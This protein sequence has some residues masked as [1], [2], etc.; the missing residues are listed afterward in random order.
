MIKIFTTWRGWVIDFLKKPTVIIVILGLLFGTGFY[1]YNNYQ[2]KKSATATQNNSDTTTQISNITN[3]DAKDFATELA[4]ELTL[5]TN[6]AKEYNTNEVLAAVEIKIPGSLVPRSGNTTYIFD[7]LS[8]TKNHFTINISQGTPNF[9]RAI[10]PIDDYF[11]K[12]TPI[13]QKSWKLSYVDVIK[14]ADKNGGQDWRSSNFLSQ[15]KLTLKNAE[16]KGWLYWFVH[17]S[18]DSTNFDVQVDAFS[19]R[20]IPPS[21]VQ[22]ATPS[23]TTS[24]QST[25][26]Q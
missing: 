26:T 25:T 15:L 1:L 19:G 13:N 9:I 22:Q 7:Q 21:E 11:G 23:T 16:P 20:V 5:A 4:A 24:D 14:I 6:K 8:D 2:Q 10:I 17:Y 3:V 12:L 18:S